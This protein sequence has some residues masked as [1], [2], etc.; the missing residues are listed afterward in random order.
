[1]VRP[2]GAQVD[3]LRRAVLAVRTGAALQFNDL[4]D[5]ATVLIPGTDVR[6]GRDTVAVL[7][8]AMI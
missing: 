2:E 6:S 4:G 8:E 1:M 3:E 5:T 7:V